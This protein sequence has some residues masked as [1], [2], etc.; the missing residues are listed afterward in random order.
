[1]KPLTEVAPVLLGQQLGRR[2]ENSLES[3][4]SGA[5]GGRCGDDRLAAADITLD[6]A[7][8]GL[9]RTDVRLD[10]GENTLLRLA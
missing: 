4:A 9:V 3:G 1:M 6:Q 7:D 2:H 10:L 5:S 8:G